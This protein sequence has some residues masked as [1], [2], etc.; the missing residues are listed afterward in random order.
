MDTPENRAMGEEPRRPDY[1]E[2][3][4]ALQRL[5]EE[6]RGLDLW[7]E[8][9]PSA[10]AMASRQPFHA[11]TLAFEQW[12]QWIFLPRMR[13]LARTGQPLPGPSRMA[14]MGEMSWR[15]RMNEL[16]S[17]IDRLEVLDRLLS[18]QQDA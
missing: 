15:Q 7:E 10:E 9:P 5:E 18:P 1:G 12:L 4:A 16:Q 17:L 3:L 2:V 14:P 6:L 11:D 8:Q 13:E